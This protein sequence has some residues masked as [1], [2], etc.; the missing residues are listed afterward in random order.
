MLLA[1]A[2][3]T[4]HT[5]SAFLLIYVAVFVALYFFYIRPRSRKTKAARVEARKVEVGER[6]QTVGGFVGTVIRQ[7]DGLVTLRS[8][9]G[10]EL[11]FIASAIARRFDPVVPESA[12]DDHAD[13]DTSGGEAAEGDK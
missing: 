10:A 12:D 8:A 1:A 11:D 3:K 4:T 9:G 2:S 5:S 6:A 7:E 13:D